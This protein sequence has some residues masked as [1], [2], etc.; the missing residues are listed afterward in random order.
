MVNYNAYKIVTAPQHV[1]L[2]ERVNA[3]IKDGWEPI[4]GPTFSD[5]QLMQAMVRYDRKGE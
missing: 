1:L 3:E 4:G 5:G 2:S